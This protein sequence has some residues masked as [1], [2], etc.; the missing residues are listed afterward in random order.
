MLFRKLEFQ[1]SPQRATTMQ[2][3]MTVTDTRSEIHRRAEKDKFLYCCNEM[4][5][6]GE[7]ISLAAY[8]T[9]LFGLKVLTRRETVA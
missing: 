5:K 6:E 7:K 1:I 9:G 3:G 8:P 2:I 4:G